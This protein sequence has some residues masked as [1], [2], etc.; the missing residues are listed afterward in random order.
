MAVEPRCRNA[1]LFLH[2]ASVINCLKKGYV[3]VDFV[4][5]GFVIE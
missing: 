5:I 4:A 1:H 3:G 2:I